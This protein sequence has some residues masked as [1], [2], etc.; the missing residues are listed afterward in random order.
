MEGSKAGNKH[1]PAMCA[2]KWPC[3]P[4]AGPWKRMGRIL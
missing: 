1:K 2:P 3:V 4:A